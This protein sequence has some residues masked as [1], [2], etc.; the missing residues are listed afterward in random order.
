MS[1]ETD[2]IDQGFL[3]Q[4]RNLIIG[5]LIVL[6]LETTVSPPESLSILGVS[7]KITNSA[8]IIYWLWI[9]TFYWLIRFFQYL[10]PLEQIREKVVAEYRL[11]MK[12]LLVRVANKEFH[13][14]IPTK[15]NSD[16]IWFISE[17]NIYFPLPIKLTKI[18]FSFMAT[19]YKNLKTGVGGT[20][21]CNPRPIFNLS[22]PWSIWF[23][24]VSAIGVCSRTALFT[25]YVI[26]VLLFAAAAVS[27]AHRFL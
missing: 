22:A 25:E 12:R 3:R 2:V 9:L 6:F 13:K 18:P 17:K 24:F 23:S 27:S 16:T 20:S 10:P 1:E 7:L 5:T 19:S 8:Y 26:P 11:S 4:R 21:N 15:Q 14:R